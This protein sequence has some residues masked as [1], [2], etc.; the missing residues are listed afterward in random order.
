MNNSFDFK[1][2]N[3]LIGG[4]TNGIGWAS[5]Q[6]FAENGGNNWLGIGSIIC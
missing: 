2:K 1:N 6:L 4:S 3:I 5:A